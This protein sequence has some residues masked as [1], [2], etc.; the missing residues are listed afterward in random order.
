MYYN[1]EQLKS[2]SC[3]K[4]FLVF[5]IFVLLFQGPADEER[6]KAATRMEKGPLFKF[7]F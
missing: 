4:Q 2:K 5:C 7:I 1:T 6:L 3:V